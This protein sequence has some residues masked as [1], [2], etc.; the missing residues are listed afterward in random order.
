MIAGE[1]EPHLSDDAKRQFLKRGQPRPVLMV[2]L[3]LDAEGSPSEINL[4]KGSGVAA[5][6]ASVLAAVGGWRFEPYVKDGEAVGL[7]TAI[8]FRYNISGPPPPRG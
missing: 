4:V 1:R 5:A 2:K 3:C 7:C 6:D 8:M